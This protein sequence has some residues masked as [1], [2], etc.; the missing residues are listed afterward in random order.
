MEAFMY[1]RRDLI[2]LLSRTDGDLS[3]AYLVS[4]CNSDE[5][6]GRQYLI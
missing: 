4:V 2:L 5:Y 3:T 1:L 6:Q